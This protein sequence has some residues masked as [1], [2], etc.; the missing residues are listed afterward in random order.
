M[1]GK[2]KAMFTDRPTDQENLQHRSPCERWG[3]RSSYRSTKLIINLFWNKMKA[4]SI[5]ESVNYSDYLEQL[6]ASFHHT[7][8]SK[9]LNRLKCYESRKVPLQMIRVDTTQVTGLH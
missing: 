1:W 9:L 7:T 2:N 8:V 5:T 3:L 6:L 4:K